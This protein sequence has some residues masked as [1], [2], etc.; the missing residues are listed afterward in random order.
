NGAKAPAVLFS[1][2]FAAVWLSYAPAGVMGTYS[3]VLLFA[4]LACSGKSWRSLVRGAGGTALG[5]G[6]AGF[7]LVPAAYEQRWVHIGQALSS[8][9]L[10][11]QNFLYT[12]IDDPEH[13]FFNWIA[14]TTAVALAIAT[15]AAALAG[16]CR[17]A[18]GVAGPR[19]YR[20]RSSAA[21][22]AV[23]MEETVWRALL[24]LAAASTLL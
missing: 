14:S 8:G 17:S 6:L 3:S 2:V 9:L 15:G 22:S 11:A 23:P 19:W 13:T 4:W 12:V 20:W 21:N 5:F 10:P 24:V 18:T 7:Y 16:R 1:V